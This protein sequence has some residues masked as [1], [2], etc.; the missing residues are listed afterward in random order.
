MYRISFFFSKLYFYLAFQINKTNKQNNKTTKHKSYAFNKRQLLSSS[1]FLTTVGVFYFFFINIFFF[2][3]PSCNVAAY[4]LL[5][6]CYLNFRAL[7]TVLLLFYFRT[8]H[9]FHSILLFNQ[10]DLQPLW[11]PI[12]KSSLNTLVKI[13]MCV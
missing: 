2:I 3:F 4:L 5:S 7:C 12:R 11:N 6:F 1:Q 8:K 9:I 13:H 10:Y